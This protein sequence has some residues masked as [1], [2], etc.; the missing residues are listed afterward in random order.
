MYNIQGKFSCGGYLLNG[1]GRADAI[2][3]GAGAAGLLCA[4]TAA[5]RGRRVLLLEKTQGPARKLRITGKG[6]CNVTSNTDLEGLMAA[7][8][9]NPRFLYSAFAA[10]MPSDTMALFEELGVP[11]KTER[12]NRVFPASDKAG[13][14]ASALI[15]YA[16]ESGAEIV[17]DT[18]AK[19]LLIENGM[20]KGVSTN[21]G[22]FHSES[23]AVATGGLSYPRTGSTGDGYRLAK[24]AGHNVTPRRPS[25]TAIVTEEDYCREL[26]IAHISAIVVELAWRF[27]REVEAC[28]ILPVADLAGLLDQPFRRRVVPRAFG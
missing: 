8:R 1:N 19:N 9:S 25:L 13:D 27:L 17:T 5:Q 4:G 11:L 6:R 28:G 21:R 16:K 18:A 7:V 24:Q 15:G 10:F 2:V 22:E 12:G 3:I 26:P 14:I 23:V 20:I